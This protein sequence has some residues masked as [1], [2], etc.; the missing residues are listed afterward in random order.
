M[1]TCPNCAEQND[2][3]VPYCAVCA[4]RV[5]PAE[6]GARP[7]TRS[8]PRVAGPPYP[9]PA[10]PWAQPGDSFGAQPPVPEPITPD[11]Q[12]SAPVD[13]VPPATE[14]PEFTASGTTPP[15]T[16]PPGTTPPGTTPLRPPG[17][18]YPGDPEAPRRPLPT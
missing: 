7:P 2:D 15:A 6:S 4:T 11:P 16:T 10:D 8:Y 1:W 5:Q 3:D 9:A 13:P 17:R 18:G 14:P 12:P